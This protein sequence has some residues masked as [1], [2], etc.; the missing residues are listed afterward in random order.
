MKRTLPSL[1][2][3]L[4]IASTLTAADWPAWRGPTGQGHSDE[5]NL[6]LKWSA[7]KTEQNV[8]WKVPLADAGNSTPVIWGDSIFVTQATKGGG[9]RSL[10][11]FARADG[12]LKWQKDVAYAEK[13][14]AYQPTWYANASPA[15]DGERV[16]VSYGSAGMYCYDFKG[17]ELWKRTDLGKWE[18]TFGN[19]ASPVLYGDLVILWCGPNGGKGRNYL[20]AVDKKTGKT[21]W[22]HD[23]TFGSWSTPLVVKVKDQDQ[24]LVGQTQ[25]VKGQPEAKWGYLKGFDPKTGKE[26]W[27]C[28]GLSSF[29]YTSPLYADGVAVNMSGYGGSAIAVKL[30]GEGDITADR[31]WMHPRPAKQRVG[32]GVIIGEHLYMVDED[33]TPH[34]YEL[35]SGNDLWKD[36]KLPNGLT[37]G[38]LV[39][40]DGRLYL[41]MRNGNTLVLAAKPKFELLANNNL[42]PG[43][44]TNSSIAISNGQIFIRTFKHLW[45]I[46]QKK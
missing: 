14:T 8:K 26:L 23:E 44:N 6:P 9:T 5:K 36:E 39:H 35:K 34:C 33:A 27:K 21:K 4:A 10:L 22:E 12:K 29:V 24:L 7:G 45:C 3:L 32:S 41:L 25:D 2:F 20:V 37:W 30:G 11:C 13:E 31:L 42:G 40:A 17:E 15:T 46:E 1:A 38:S 19:S 18:H 28:R 43:E 16:I